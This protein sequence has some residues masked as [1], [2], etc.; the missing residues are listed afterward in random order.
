MRRLLKLIRWSLA[1]VGALIVL[2][3]VTVAGALWATLPRE[4]QDARIPGLSAPVQIGFDADGIP[5]IQA[6][7]PSEVWAKV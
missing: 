7:N 2:L 5:R 1:A 4:Q 6:A 3:A